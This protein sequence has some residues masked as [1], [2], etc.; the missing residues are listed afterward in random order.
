M[1]DNTPCFF[2]SSTGG[3]YNV[4]NPATPKDAVE[5]TT[6]QRATLLAGQATGQIITA[7]AGGNPILVDAPSLTPIQVAINSKTNILA[8]FPPLDI[9]L[10]RALEDYW[11]AISFDTTKLPA[12]QQQRLA[13]KKA[14]RAQIAPILAEIDTPFI[15]GV[16]NAS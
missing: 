11:I 1:V 7:D 12:I 8:Q 6:D 10:P 13:E 16:T 15:K 14:L 4:G 5:I 3:F 9:F 2:S